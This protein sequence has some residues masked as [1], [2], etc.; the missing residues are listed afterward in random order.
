[1]TALLYM[2]PF[3]MKIP[4]IFV[5]DTIILFMWIVLFGIFGN[6]SFVD[7]FSR[8]IYT[9]INA[10]DPIHDSKDREEPR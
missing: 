10:R 4:F 2:I 3:T 6:V 5:W 8:R 1:M 9:T 7:P